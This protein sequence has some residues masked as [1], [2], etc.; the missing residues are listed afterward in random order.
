MGLNQVSFGF[1]SGETLDRL[2]QLVDEDHPFWTEQVREALTTLR[3][4]VEGALSRGELD[5]SITMK[6]IVYRRFLFD[7]RVALWRDTEGS[8]VIHYTFSDEP[9]VLMVSQ[10]E[11]V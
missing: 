4:A 7:E 3:G 6:R 9:E 8:W 2:D 11:F 1:L 10:I 5:R